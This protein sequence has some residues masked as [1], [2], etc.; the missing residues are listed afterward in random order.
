MCP[1]L[2][3]CRILDVRSD[4]GAISELKRKVA[5]GQ[6]E[7]PVR[8]IR[9]NFWIAFS[10]GKRSLG[11]AG[12]HFECP[13]WSGWWVAVGSATIRKPRTILRAAFACLINS[14]KYGTHYS[15]QRLWSLLPQSFVLGPRI[16]CLSDWQSSKAAKSI[17][18][19]SLARWIGSSDR[20][21]SIRSSSRTERS[22]Y[23]LWSWFVLS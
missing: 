9:L 12:A 14:F 2:K 5:S 1:P 15:L 6:G 22:L 7:P 4:R 3:G 16:F 8:W 21:V 17:A 10:P 20:S 13:A 23:R 19:E 11:W 18:A